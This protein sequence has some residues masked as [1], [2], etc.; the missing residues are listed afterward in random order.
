MPTP[1]INEE[2]SLI[3]AL[4]K[5]A[6]ADDYVHHFEQMNIQMLS[7]ALGVNHAEIALLKQNLDDVPV[8]P[9]ET[10][11]QKLEYFWRILTMMKMDLTAD[12][13]EL[14]LAKELG[15]AM[16]LSKFEVTGLVSHM[17]ENVLGFVSFE[18]FMEYA[19]ELENHPDNLAPTTF[20]E[21]LKAL[22]R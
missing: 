14:I 3:I 1:K 21:K 11:D 20:Y 6:Q 10:K 13:R 4:I 7:N 15:L 8:V 17:V 2:T 19:T 22:F 18:E 5:M 9:P 16:D 12:E